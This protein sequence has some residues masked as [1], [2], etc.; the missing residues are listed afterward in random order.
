MRRMT[1]T[2]TREELYALVWSEPIQKIAPRYGLSDRGFGKM[3]ARYEIPVPPRGW[4]AKKAAG[5][6]LK[7]PPLPPLNDPYLQKIRFDK[8]P[9]E[10]AA[11]QPAPEV[12]PLI[13]FEQDAP[14][15]I[16]VPTEGELTNPLVLKTQRLLNRAKRDA[17]GLIAAPAAALHIHASRALH[18]RSLR[19]MQALLAAFEARGFAVTQTAEGAR[20]NILE[21]SLGFGIEE[22]TKKVE[23]ATTFT[24][25]KLIDRGMGWQVPKHDTVPNG[26]LT[27]VI[28]NVS[29]LRQ[30]WSEAPTRPLEGSLNKFIIGLVRAALGLKRQRAEAERRE[31]ERQEEERKRQEEARRLEEAERAWR[32]EQARVERLIRLEAVWTRNQK[33]R[34]LVSALRQVLGEVETESE[35]GK[36]LSWAETYANRSDP[37]NR[38]RARKAETLT[39]YYHGY[40][41]DRVAR[42]GAG[43]LL[44]G[45]MRSAWKWRQLR[46]RCLLESQQATCRGWRCGSRDGQAKHESRATIRQWNQ[47]AGTPPGMS[48]QHVEP[49]VYV[50]Q[51]LVPIPRTRRQW[52]PV[53]AQ[54]SA[55]EAPLVLGPLTARTIARTWCE[56]RNRNPHSKH[57]GRR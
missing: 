22:G 30:R 15:R 19:I 51:H 42:E 33:L 57:R 1:T 43:R 18:E 3:C 37:L 49:C 54:R 40:D 17:D 44:K 55:T 28:T 4:W 12:H 53:M 23:H 41:S 7:Q 45:T 16:S 9:R 38:F 13:A 24:E 34:E 8:T 29:A 46:E 48:R 21:E 31:R 26:M 56:I 47:I 10:I 27:F 2:L 25:Q 35:L 20:V 50:F 5:K 36:W 52:L 32:E 39:L 11:N 6:R 14:N